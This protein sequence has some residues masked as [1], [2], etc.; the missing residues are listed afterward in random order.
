VAPDG[1]PQIVR[2]ARPYR[3]EVGLG[4]HTIES[5]LREMIARD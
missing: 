4:M 3:R 1:R 2:S 5:L